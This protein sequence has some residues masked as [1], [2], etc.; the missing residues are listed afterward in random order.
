M[1]DI[2]HIT[3]NYTLHHTSTRRGYISRKLPGKVQ[4]YSGRFGS[5]YIIIRP[6]RDSSQYVTYEYYLD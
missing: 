5:G 3:A 6:R 1:L 2:T 4:P